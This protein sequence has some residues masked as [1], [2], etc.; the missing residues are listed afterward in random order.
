MNFVEEPIIQPLIR[1]GLMEIENL[2]GC[3][4]AEIKK[5]MEAQKVLY[6]PEVHKMFLKRL[7]KSGAEVL[8]Q[9]L[10]Y[11]GQIENKEIMIEDVYSGHIEGWYE[12]PLVELPPD[13]FVHFYGDGLI[14]EFFRVSESVDDPEI[15]MYP[16]GGTYYEKRAYTLTGFFRKMVKERIRLSTSGTKT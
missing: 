16:P 1:N 10:T 12:G 8:S 15:F 3:S 5:I 7:G 11:Q 9:S 14:Y 4:D 2:E 6:L 13:I